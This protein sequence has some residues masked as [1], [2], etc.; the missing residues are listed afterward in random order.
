[1]KKTTLFMAALLA[2]TMFSSQAWAGT[3]TQDDPYTVAEAQQNQDESTAWVKGFIVGGVVSDNTVSTID[4]NDDVVW[5][6]EGVRATTV[7]IADGKDTKDYNQCVAVKLDSDARTVINLA[8]NPG[9]IGKELKVKGTLKTSFGI[10]GIHDVT[11]DFE[12]EG[13]EAPNYIFRE[14]FA[15]GQGDFTTYEV[16]NT[17]PEGDTH[18]VWYY[19]SK[20]KQMVAGAY[21]DDTNY[22]TEAW[23]ISP[24]IDLSNVSTATFT[25]DHAG[26]QFGA[27]TTNLTVQAS[28]NY[29][30]GDVTAATWTELPIPNHLS[31]E[32]NTFKSAGDMDLAAFCGQANVRIAFKYTSTTTGA[33]NWYIQNVKVTGETTGSGIA[34]VAADET[35]FY[36]LDGVLMLGGV[37]EGTQVEI[38]NALGA[39]MM[40]TVFDGTGIAV[41]DLNPGMYIVRAGKN[42]KKVMF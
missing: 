8:D 1:M 25:F 35:A 10:A 15:D 23:L 37:A 39:R 11:T 41:N 17:K 6:A 26:K 40:T 18:S 34:G 14:T 24:A 19:N 2:G 12:L 20:R 21:V 22:E 13:Y 16:K 33:G 28:S 42:A 7:L 29:T 38:Y 3:G 31:G 32:T 27:P 30:E 36:V 9:N 5:G 4:S